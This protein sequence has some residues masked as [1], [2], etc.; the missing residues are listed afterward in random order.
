VIVW[1]SEE[2]A[3][4]G[5]KIGMTLIKVEGIKVSN[6]KQKEAIKIIKAHPE[7]PLRVTFAAAAKKSP[8]A[9][10]AAAATTTTTTEDDNIIP[11]D[12]IISDD[13][14][15]DDDTS[16]VEEMNRV[17]DGVEP[18]D[19]IF[20]MT[21][22]RK[23]Q[24]QLESGDLT[25][26]DYDQTIA[27]FGFPK[28]ALEQADAALRRERLDREAE[29]AEK[30]KVVEEKR[31]ETLSE[32]QKSLVFVS[33]GKPTPEVKLLE[34]GGKHNRNLILQ[35]EMQRVRSKHSVFVSSTREMYV[36]LL[37]DMLIVSDRK[38]SLFKKKEK[39]QLL[40]VRYEVEEVVRLDVVGVVT[41]TDLRFMK[42]SPEHSFKVTS[43]SR[44][45]IF[46]APNK[47]TKTKW[48]NALK[49]QILKNTPSD[50]RDSMV[51]Y[52][53]IVLGGTFFSACM[54]GRQDILKRLL[55]SDV[56]ADE[57][58][59]LDSHGYT[60][61]HYAAKTGN[62]KCMGLLCSSPLVIK[63]IASSR[64]EHEMP[65]HMTVSK[66][67]AQCTLVLKREKTSLSLSLTHTHT[68]F[69]LLVLVRLASL[70]SPQ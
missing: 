11:D 34:D 65:L 26:S 22:M 48:L 15:E 25:Q 16:F 23:L 39:G 24:S 64:S 57:I 10:A 51:G 36:F 3:K 67:H 12:N 47:E 61:L 50:V 55:E 8:T 68:H 40:S 32:I 17:D 54:I 53:H 43:P 58:N 20:I 59:A 49:T 45:H 63:D 29:E 6:M 7:R 60:A 35:G 5:A 69:T 66:E 9:T 30:A 1:V 27:S 38:K 14:K 52:E 46:V 42:D 41:L 18:Q 70:N 28:K 62:S 21:S 2:S 19:M 37:S 31:V 33:K 4:L 13:V 44:D 56:K